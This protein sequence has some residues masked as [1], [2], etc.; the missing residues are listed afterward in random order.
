MFEDVF[1]DYL[2]YLRYE[3][4]LSENT[5]NAYQRDIRAFTEWLQTEGVDVFDVDIVVAR[6]YLFQLNKEKLSKNSVSRKV[7]SIKS[8][9]GYLLETGQ[10]DQN[11]F[12]TIHAPKKDKMLPKVINEIDMEQFFDKIYEKHD[13]LSQRDQVLFELLYGSGLRVSEAV[14]LDV[15]DVTQGGVIRILGKGRKERIVPISEKTIEVLQ[16]YLAESGGRAAI[17]ADRRSEE[18]DEAALLLNHL[19]TRLTRRGVI[20]II[21]KYVEQGAVHYHVSPHAFRHSF[22]TH[23][24]DHGADLKLIQELLGHS[25]LST[26]QIYTK[27]SAKRLRELYNAGHPHA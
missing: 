27:V 21:D 18:C 6:T 15:A 24:L 10:I 11:P 12:Q 3:R 8:L 7:S 26:T 17:L 5:I 23:L 16:C 25:S 2:R 20:Y 19:G 9:Y 22:A 1:A 14:A 4:N 13:P